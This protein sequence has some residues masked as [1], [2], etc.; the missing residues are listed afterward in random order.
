[1]FTS[2]QYLKILIIKSSLGLGEEMQSYSSSFSAGHNSYGQD[3]HATTIL[4][5]RKGNLLCIG[6]DGQI[7]QGMTVFKTKVKKIRQL[8][9]GRVLA[10]FAGVTVD[11]LAIFSYLESY[12]DHYPD[13]TRACV[14][15]VREW[16]ANTNGAKLDAFV[17]VCDDYKTLVLSGAGDVIEPDSNIVGIGSGGLYALSAANALYDNTALDAKQIVEK[18]LKIASQLCVFTNENFTLMT[19][20]LPTSNFPTS[21]DPN[22]PGNHAA[23]FNPSESNRP[24]E[25]NGSAESNQISEGKDLSEDQGGVS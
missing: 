23:S 2:V 6:G 10:G 7:S 9:N 16:R 11:A 13:L 14:E 19:K 8:A 20:T 12:L 18:S 15:M 24:F 1:M 17:I 25:G 4:C 5:V 21:N 22:N 3:F